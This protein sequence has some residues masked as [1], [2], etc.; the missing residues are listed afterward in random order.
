MT[1]KNVNRSAGR[2]FYLPTNEYISLTESRP[3]RFWDFR[4]ALLFCIVVLPCLFSA[5][6]W[7][8]TDIVVGKAASADGSVIVSHTGGAPDCRVHVVPARTHEP[9]SM[10][11]VYFGLLDAKVPFGE[12][13]E[14]IGYIPQVERTY[15][16]FHSAYSHMNEFQL[17]IG[18]STMAQREELKCERKSGAKQI[19]TVE[20][21]QAFALQRCRK[22]REAVDLIGGLVLRYGFLPSAGGESEALCIADTEE[23]W[24]MEIYSVGGEWEP[25][26]G[27]PGAI[28]AAQRVPDDHAAVV[29]NWSI[30]KEIDAD[31]PDWFKVSPNYIQAAV[32]RGWYDPESGRPFIWQEAYAPPV[33]GEGAINRLWLFYST[34]APSLM[35]YPDRA[36]ARP[37]TGYD[38]YHHP[39]E[40]LSFYPFSAAPEKKLSVRDVI[41]FQRS[42]FEGTI[43]DMTADADWLVPD[44]EGNLVKSPMTTPF[45]TEAMRQL[46]DITWHRNVSKGGYGMVTQ[47]RGWLPDAIGGVYWLYLD[48]QYVSTYVPIYA[49]VQEIHPAYRVYHPEQFSEDS[50][51]WVIDFVDNLLYLRWQPAM[52]EVRARRD[53][54]E[55]EF[56][57][58]QAEVEEDALALYE[59]SPAEAEAYLTRYTHQCMD[60]VVTLYREL[61]TI[62]L[63]KFTNNT[64]WL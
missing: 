17:A 54:L 46:L 60:R 51:R 12:Y 41:R 18:E 5:A 57:S 59:K 24:V 14:V 20:Q 26:S 50:A 35:D 43:Y 8:C 53:P 25:A 48:N 7:C 52:A 19:M 21:A 44:K 27:E 11:P 23:A 30:I 42:V 61:R 64:E 4:I 56:F 62:I 1:S 13:G 40:P 9:G 38:A 32:D 31:Q 16:Y 3:F 2:A 39:Q 28:W 36:L 55:A 29:P 58:D 15:R 6:G 63:S 37:F 47:L 22:A 49:G 34:V 10:A 45:P 33:T